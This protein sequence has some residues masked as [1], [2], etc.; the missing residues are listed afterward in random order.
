MTTCECGQPGTEVCFKRGTS[1]E[2]WFCGARKH[3]ARV[4]ELSAQ[5][6]HSQ[7]AVTAVSPMGTAIR[8]RMQAGHA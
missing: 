3:N 4:R 8:R 1:T 2:I 7:S 5:G 6:W